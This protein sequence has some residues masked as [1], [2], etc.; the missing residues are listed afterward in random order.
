MTQQ[1]S[2]AIPTAPPVLACRLRHSALRRGNPPTAG[3]IELE[4]TSARIVEIAWEGGCVSLQ[5]HSSYVSDLVSHQR[6]V[7]PLCRHG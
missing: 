6:M 4:N 2:P 1:T 5:P 7:R 3:E